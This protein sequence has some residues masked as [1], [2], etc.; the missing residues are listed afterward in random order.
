MLDRW[1]AGAP[2]FEDAIQ[3]FEI[4]PAVIDVG[5]HEQDIRGAIGRPGAKGLRRDQALHSDAA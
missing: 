1:A 3:A 4:W 5:T 2:Q